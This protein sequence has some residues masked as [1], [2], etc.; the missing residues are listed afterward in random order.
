MRDFYDLIIWQKSHQLT[1]SIY[2]ATGYF[3]KD[4]QFGLI[5]QMRR[6]SSSI[7]ANIAEGCGRSTNAQLKYFFSVATGSWSELKYQ[8][9]LCKYLNYI[10]QKNFTLLSENVVVIRKMISTFINKLPL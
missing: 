9:L 10:D 4:E 5:S 8:L 6:S 1:L 3:P 2:F 7:P